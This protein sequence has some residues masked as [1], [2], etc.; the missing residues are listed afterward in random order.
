M[1]HIACSKYDK[2]SDDET[3]QG[4]SNGIS[5]HRADVRYHTP[6][7]MEVRVN[8]AGNLPSWKKKT[9]VI[10]AGLM[11]IKMMKA[12]FFTTE[13]NFNTASSRT[14]K[15]ITNDRSRLPAGFSAHVCFVISL[16]YVFQAKI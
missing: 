14:T 7:A 3:G 2:A 6:N 10:Q 4:F 16:I 13:E 5:E 8:A 12:L 1:D 11:M 9:E 15:R